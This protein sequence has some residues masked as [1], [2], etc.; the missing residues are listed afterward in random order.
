MHDQV[1]NVLREFFLWLRLLIE[2]AAGVTIAV[3][4]VA[5]V[6]T[7]VRRL[8]TPMADTAMRLTLARHLAIAL[9]LQLAADVVSTAMAPTWSDIGRMAAIAVVRTLL[10]YFLGRELT[11][12]RRELAGSEPEHDRPERARPADHSPPATSDS[13]AAGG[14]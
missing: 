1:E 9:E 12:H 14:G 5:S 7:A 13:T 4:L 8:R 2:C 3:G 10:N 6:V 11:A